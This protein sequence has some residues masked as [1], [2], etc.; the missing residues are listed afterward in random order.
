M[1]GHLPNGDADTH[2]LHRYGFLPVTSG[3][4]KEK[5]FHSSPEKAISFLQQCIL[6]GSV[7]RGCVLIQYN[8][9]TSVF[10]GQKIYM[11]VS[12]QYRGLEREEEAAV[13]PQRVVLIGTYF[14]H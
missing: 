1:S 2:F 3:Q 12:F 10:S 9:C 4:C 6:L 13:F 7:S 11:S 5:K 8:P 14:V